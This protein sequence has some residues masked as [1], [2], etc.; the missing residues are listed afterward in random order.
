MHPPFGKQSITESAPNMLASVLRTPPSKT[1]EKTSRAR[2][3]FGGFC[4][5]IPTK[6]LNVLQIFQ[7]SATPP[8]PTHTTSP[9]NGST[10]S[11]NRTSTK[12]DP[13]LHKRVDPPEG[14]VPK[15][16]HVEYVGFSASQELSFLPLV[17]RGWTALERGMKILP[18]AI[19]NDF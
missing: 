6:P 2:E 7:L 17:S 13:P 5:F 8:L 16:L 14:G 18:C 19:T 15:T 12:K 4:T 11:P 1:I 9:Q 3:K 10:P